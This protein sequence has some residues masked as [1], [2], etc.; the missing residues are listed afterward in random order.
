MLLGCGNYNLFPGYFNYKPCIIVLLLVIFFTASTGLAGASENSVQA[1]KISVDAPGDHTGYA[2]TVDPYGNIYVAGTSSKTWATTPIRPYSGGIADCYVAKFNDQGILLWNTFL[3]GSGFDACRGIAADEQQNVY[4]T[5][6]SGSS[7]SPHLSG[8]GG[9]SSDC[10]VTKL[11]NRGNVKWNTFLGGK[12]YDT[13]NALVVDKRQ[14]IFVTGNS[15]GSWGSP[16]ASHDEGGHNG[17]AAKLDARGEL[18]WNTFFGG[19]DYDGS[20]A[21]AL[22]ENNNLFIAGESFSGWGAPVTEFV[23]GYYGNYDAFVIKLDQD[24]SV[25]WNTFIGGTGSDYGRGIDL[26]VMGNIY[27]TGNSNAPWGK[28][29]MPYTGDSDIYVAVLNENGKLVWNLFLGGEG[30]DYGRDIAVNWTGNLFV[31]GQTASLR[32]GP[33]QQS[34]WQGSAFIAKMQGKGDLQWHVLLQGMG[35]GYGHDLAVDAV[36]NVFTT[37]HYSAYPSQNGP[38]IKGFRSA[39]L[40]KLNNAGDLKWKIFIGAQ[41][42]ARMDE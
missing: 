13:G 35:S 1:R 8:F 9:G 33:D 40:S 22:D 5:G 24:G 31:T 32:D 12:Q 15:I 21:L 36:G 42:A 18:Q 34:A 7:W 17:F 6:E 26:D 41:V 30:P 19:D 16:I 3:G 29:L 25:Q 20:Y 38:G 14:N 11:D 27:V 23:R 28:P 2:V 37:G 10:F 4:V 39:F